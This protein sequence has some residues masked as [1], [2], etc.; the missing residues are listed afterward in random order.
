MNN[1][2][3]LLLPIKDLTD[4]NLTLLEVALLS[5]FAYMK[6]AF[7]EIYPSNAY[8]SNLLNVSSR[9]IQR[10]INMLSKYNYITFRIE[11]KN[12]RYIELTD[13]CNSSYKMIY[14]D[15]EYNEVLINDNTK[16]NP[17]LDKFLKNLND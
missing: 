12:K 4:K 15:I 14:K 8:L 9:S 1:T 5:Q 17:V 16:R 7:K 3:Y 10:A 2:A 6:K 13:K 11:N